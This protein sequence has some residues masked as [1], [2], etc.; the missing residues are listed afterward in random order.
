M[1]VPAPKKFAVKMIVFAKERSIV[2]NLDF[3]GVY[4]IPHKNVI[5]EMGEPVATVVTSN[6]VLED[7]IYSAK[8]LVGK[9]YNALKS[10]PL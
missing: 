7:A 2:G 4:D 6:R 5:I 10:F 1:D 9:V 3:D 8:L